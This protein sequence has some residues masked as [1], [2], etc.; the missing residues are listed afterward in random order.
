MGAPRKEV[1]LTHWDVFIS[2]CLPDENF[3]TNLGARLEDVGLKVFL[4]AWDITAGES[5]VGRTDD[6]ITGSD[7]AII[8][9]GRGAHGVTEEYRTLASQFNA[10]RLRRLVPVLVHEDLEVRLPPGLS[11]QAPLSFAGVIDAHSFGVQVGALVDALRGKRARGPV[12]PDFGVPPD[13]A[14]VTDQPV[15]TTLRFGERDTTLSIEGRAPV[16]APH[17]GVTPMLRNALWAAERA[18]RTADRMFRTSGTG[19]AGPGSPDLDAASRAVGLRLAETF[20]AGQVGT[21]LGAHLEE[22]GRAGKAVHLAVEAC[23]GLSDLPWESLLLP[24]DPVPLCLQPSVRLYR[25]LTGLGPTARPDVPGP[26]RV[27]AVIASP[28]VGGGELLDYEHELARILD[29]VEVARKDAGAHVRILNWGSAAAIREALTEERFHVLHISC[30]AKPGVLLLENEEGAVDP[31]DADRFADELRVTGTLVPLVVLAGCSTALAGERDSLPSVARRLLERGVP[32]V[33]AM[34]AAVSDDYATEVLART[35][36]ELAVA[37]N[38]PE[39]L[40]AITVARWE[41]EQRR[42]SLPEGDGR[43][44]LAEWAT[45]AY[46]QR[47]R[48]NRLFQPGDHEEPPRPSGRVGLPGIADLR[49]GDFVGRR[50]ELR[51]LIRTLRESGGGV[52]IHGMGGVGKSSLAAQLVHAVCDE[53]TV[54]VS[55]HGRCTVDQVLRKIAKRLRRHS[56]A[57]RETLDD[58]EDDGVPWRER[59]ED[60]AATVLP[61]L[62]ARVLLLL[63]DPVGDPLETGS[64]ADGEHVRPEDGL[65]EF[66]GAW[67]G[68]GGPARLIVTSRHREPLGGAAGRRL[69][70]HHL[71]PLSEAETRKLIFRLP[72]VD[73]LPPADRQRVHRDLGGHPRALEYLDAVLRSGRKVRARKGSGEQFG[74]VMDR[75]ELALKSTGQDAETW[76]GER[77]LDTALAET[78]AIAASDVLL[79]RLHTDLS[80]SFP[81]AAELFVAASVY[82]VPVDDAGLLWA[83]APLWTPDDDPAMRD[84]LAEAY[85]VLRRGHHLPREAYEQLMRDLADMAYPRER[86]GLPAARDRLLDLTLLAPVRVPVDDGGPPLEQYLVHRWT[87]KKLSA[88]VDPAALVTAHTR[89]AAYHLWRAKL[90][91]REPEVQLDSLEEV[92]H[93]SWAAGLRDQAVVVTAEMCAV[94]DRLG[95]RDREWSLCEDVLGR[96]G[97]DTAEAQVFH[98]RMSVLA[99]Q[100][101]DFAVAESCQRRALV[102]AAGDRTAEATGFQQLGTIAQLRGD[103]AGAEAAYHRA[104]AIVRDGSVADQV[105]ARVLLAGSYQRLGG[106]ALGRG[107]DDS[108][109]R[110][111]IGALDVADG[112]EHEAAD[113]IA[114]AELAALAVVVGDHATARR[115]GLL[116]QEMTAAGLDVRRLMAAASLQLGTVCLTRGLLDEAEHHLEEAETLAEEVR[117]V[118]LQ[119]SCLQLLGEVQM[120]RAEHEAARTTYEVF[121]ECADALDDRRG[122]V[123]AQQQLARICALTDDPAGATEALAAASAI[124]ERLGSDLLVGTTRLVHGGVLAGAGELGEAAARFR[125]GREIAERIGER[126]LALACVLQLALLQLRRNDLTAAEALFVDGARRAYD[127]GSTRT[128]ATCLLALGLIA[129][130]RRADGAASELY[131]R[132]L[133]LATRE[134]HPRLEAECLARLA[135]IALDHGRNDEAE[136]LYSRCLELL[137]TVGAPHLKADVLRQLGR[138]RLYRGEPRKAAES[139]TRAEKAFTELREPVWVLFC[140]VCLAWVLPRAGRPKHASGVKRRAGEI[141]AA[142]LPPRLRVAGLLLAGEHAAETAEPAA[143]RDRFRTALQVARDVGE[144]QLIIDCFCHLAQLAKDH[145]RPAEARSAMEY[146]LEIATREDDQMLAMHLHRELGLI[147]AAAGDPERAWRHFGRSAEHAGRLGER[148]AHAAARALASGGD[149][150]ELM[151]A[152]EDEFAELM[153]LRRVRAADTGAV[154]DDRMAAYAGAPIDEIVTGLVPQF[155]GVSGVPAVVCPSVTS[156]SRHHYASGPSDVR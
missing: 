138:C 126:G 37:S 92:R 101:L 68:L 43:R 63:D 141:D 110:F 34:T 18:R 99:V 78:I 76:R 122:Q 65:G 67:L 20:V 11:D 135:D 94:L 139:L 6:G 44:L 96:V 97:P 137:D 21:A 5:T 114:H 47:T 87:A 143:A 15:W 51:T 60:F 118:P 146:A 106:L 79:D 130:D 109:E 105:G 103:N 152:V 64:V 144:P 26:L 58:L 100:R 25:R 127:L 85:R 74:A 80:A 147:I 56:G 73:A 10:K 153:S 128:R 19:R 88:Q 93:H 119:A 29:E 131:G 31:V 113:L 112:I 32:S 75:I 69:V 70:T 40:A 145:G 50:A 121:A 27:L 59:L 28:D 30:H 129:C 8:V 9:V 104:M 52:L 149:P 77:T 4:R 71:G 83:V 24:G 1:D 22:V 14:R 89:A 123:L 72:A 120:N 155:S 86:A 136:D 154:F 133:V 12:E 91:E 125:E 90:W 156:V 62:G 36:R 35:Y 102:L 134:P 39:P 148:E 54:L 98:H 107:D 150:G 116:V 38:A 2:Y 57:D 46:F 23:D 53:R 115:H 13:S 66:L 95:W 132:A 7:N 111:S 124:A 45:P 108:A 61:S 82:R 84:R 33:L 41:L 81:L 3:A 140:L 42:R 151:A 117:D 16:A 48:G 142:D 55:A 17:A 49:L